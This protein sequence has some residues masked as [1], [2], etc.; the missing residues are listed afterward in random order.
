MTT[1]TQT[2]TPA[3]MHSGTHTGTAPHASTDRRPLVRGG[4]VGASTALAGNAAVFAFGSIGEPIRVV[5][6]ADATPTAL[7]LF[8]IAA[9]TVLAVAVGTVA[10]WVT[11]R[12]RLRDRTWAIGATVVAVASAVPL[13]RLEID[14]TSQLMLTVMHLLTGACCIAAHTRRT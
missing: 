4:V 11:R 5:I 9:T 10:L 12:C 7:S 6:G 8:E 14:A 2:V 3:V 13:W 1:T